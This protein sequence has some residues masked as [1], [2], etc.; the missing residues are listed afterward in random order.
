MKDEI[1]NANQ[2]Y[3]QDTICEIVKDFLKKDIDDTQLRRI[4][5]EEFIIYNR[6]IEKN[7]D[8]H[9]IN[10]DSLDKVEEIMELIKMNIRALRCGEGEK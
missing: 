4:G 9:I 1:I 7:N 2:I 5:P 3:L 8:L 10:I 6:F